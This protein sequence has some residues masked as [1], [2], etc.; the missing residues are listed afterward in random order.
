[1]R[2]GQEIV[3]EECFWEELVWNKQNLGQNLCKNIIKSIKLPRFSEVSFLKNINNIIQTI[4]IWNNVREY[5]NFIVNNNILN[6]IRNDKTSENPI[7]L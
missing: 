7:F 4:I 3:C 1:M 2:K 5:P 6:N